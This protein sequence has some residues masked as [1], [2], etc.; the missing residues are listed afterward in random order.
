LR[1]AQLVQASGGGFIL[2]EAGH[3]AAQEL[4]HRHRVY[5]SYLGNLGYAEDHL[6]PAADRA[7]HFISPQLVKTVDAAVGNPLVDPHGKPI[8]HDER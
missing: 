2:T 7:E 8:P 6:H 4:V 3:R 1:A 5:E